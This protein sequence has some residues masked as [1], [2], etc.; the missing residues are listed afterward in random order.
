MSR[1][2]TGI[3]IVAWWMQEM[4]SVGR[5]E[6]SDDAVEDLHRI[7]DSAICAE[8]IDL[9]E[10]EL[11]RASISPIEGPVEKHSHLWWRRAIRMAD[12]SQFLDFDI[13]GDDEFNN[14]A[15]DYVIVYRLITPDEKIKFRRLG[16]RYVIARVLHNR[17]F[18]PHYPGI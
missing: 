16:D 15:C 1:A 4:V 5:V 13:D 7:P 10:T 12:V 9:A 11:K 6:W 8:I 18:L 3:S 17:E 2:R 14:Q